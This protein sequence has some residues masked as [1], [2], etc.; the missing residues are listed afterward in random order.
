M[1]LITRQG[2]GSKLTI[3]EMDGNLDYLESLGFPYEGDATI[4]GTWGF[5][6]PSGMQLIGGDNFEVIISEALFIGSGVG[7]FYESEE[8]KLYNFLGDGEINITTEISFPV[9]ATIMGLDSNN[10][11]LQISS[12]FLDQEDFGLSKFIQNL[13]ESQFEINGVS[14][15]FEMAQTKDTVNN[16]GRFGITKDVTDFSSFS[17]GISL[18]TDDGIDNGFTIQTDIEDEIKLFKI[19]DDES[20]EVFGVTQLHVVMEKVVNYD[21]ADDAAAETA[22]VPVGG[23]YHTNGT[24]KIRLS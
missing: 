3:Q 23:I 2:K 5:E 21:Y 13:M 20:D 14:N 9:K 16:I 8:L 22:G 24:L 17:N 12:R 7:N 11:R 6:T 1:T 10:D 19:L 4:T 18:F 15:V